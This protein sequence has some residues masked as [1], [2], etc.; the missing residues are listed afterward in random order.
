MDLERRDWEYGPRQRGTVKTRL[1]RNSR[2]CRTLRTRK[3]KRDNLLRNKLLARREKFQMDLSFNV[4]AE[5]LKMLTILA[6]Q[7]NVQRNQKRNI[8]RLI[9]K[10]E[11]LNRDTFS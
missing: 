2:G 7:R 5:L 8:C 11:H 3:E 9:F 10:N 6:S 1:M 4:K